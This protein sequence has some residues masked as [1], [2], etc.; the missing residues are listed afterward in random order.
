MHIYRHNHITDGSSDWVVFCARIL[1]N[2][3]LR[4]HAQS[5]LTVLCR[6]AHCKEYVV[7]TV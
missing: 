1:I 7:I 2:L 6:R 5:L 4:T 3:M